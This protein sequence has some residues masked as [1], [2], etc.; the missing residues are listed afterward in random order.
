[1]L[2]RQ[3]KENDRRVDRNE[4][5]RVL[6]YNDRWIDLYNENKV[7]NNVLLDRQN[8]KKEIVEC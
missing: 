8:E 1:M 4:R 6:E 2:D 5:N 7:R 3:N